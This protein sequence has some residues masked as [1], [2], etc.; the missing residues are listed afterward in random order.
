MQEFYI[1]LHVVCLIH[2]LYEKKGV[3]FCSF[4]NVTWLEWN[5][6]ATISFELHLRGKINI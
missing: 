4:T 3:Y 6:H 2:E 1:R 5:F